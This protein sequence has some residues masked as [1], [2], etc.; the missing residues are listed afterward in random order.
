[1]SLTPPTSHTQR[2]FQPKKFLVGFIP[3]QQS[4]A[5]KLC[6]NHLCY[7]H[8]AMFGIEC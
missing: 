4:E 3:L 6:Q 5:L 1:M 8:Q 7:N 2:C